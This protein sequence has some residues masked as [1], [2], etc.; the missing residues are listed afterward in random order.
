MKGEGFGVFVDG[1]DTADGVEDYGDSIATHVEG[2]DFAVFGS[3]VGDVGFLSQKEGD[4]DAEVR[5]PS[6]FKGWFLWK[7]LYC[8][9]MVDCKADKE[10]CQGDEEFLGGGPSRGEVCEGSHGGTYPFT[11]PLYRPRN[12]SRQV[13]NLQ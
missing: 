3:E 9:N 2:E 11:G 7:G 6:F 1:G 5:C 10:E 4:C 8:Q 12:R 13:H